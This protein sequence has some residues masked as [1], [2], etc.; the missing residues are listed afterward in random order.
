MLGMMWQSWKARDLIRDPRLTIS[1]VQ[2]DRECRQG[3]LKL[4]GLARDVPEPHR[5]K[6]LEA[7]QEALISWRPAE[8]YHLFAIDILRAGFISF[9]QERRLMRW[10]TESGLEV[11][12]HPDPPPQATDDS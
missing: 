5:R 10:S 4:Y 12:R 3:D 9:G 8:P 11:L 2:S 1:T 7:A 6:A